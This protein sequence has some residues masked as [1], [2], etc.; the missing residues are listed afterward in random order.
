MTTM[1]GQTAHSAS[2]RSAVTGAKTITAASS[3]TAVALS[4]SRARARRI[5]QNAW[6]TAAASA[7]VN[8]RGGIA[9][10]E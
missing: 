1:N 3:A 2:K 5:F 4:V 7:R 10:A 6:R 8:A 9:R